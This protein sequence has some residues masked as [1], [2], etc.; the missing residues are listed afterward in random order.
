MPHDMDGAELKAGDRVLVECVVK[1]L[2]T[3]EDYCNANLE[4]AVPMQPE[5]APVALV[6]NAKQVRK[7]PE[8]PPREPPSDA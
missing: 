5:G 8:L 1:T 6:V 4:T 7:L 2:S 3:G